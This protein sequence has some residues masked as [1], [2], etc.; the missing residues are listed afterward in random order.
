[1]TNGLLTSARRK[2]FLSMICKK[3]PNNLTFAL[4]YKKYKNNLTKIIRLAK[5]NFYEQKFK[6]ASSKPKSTWNLINEVT[7]SKLRFEDD[8]VRL[9]H[10]ECKVNVKNDPITA[11]NMFNDF[12][13]KYRSE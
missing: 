3:H 7:G 12:F 8:I 2:Q 13:Y 11:S 5:N 10:N 6:N 1:M 4:Y 9:K